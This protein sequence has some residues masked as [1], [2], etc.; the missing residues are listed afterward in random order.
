MES[1]DP[2]SDVQLDLEH[3]HVPH[4]A[5]VDDP[6]TAALARPRF[7]DPQHCRPP[8]SDLRGDHSG[9]QPSLVQVDCPTFKAVRDPRPPTIKDGSPASCWCSFRS[10][11]QRRHLGRITPTVV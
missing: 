1:H 11:H 5:S 3:A 8:D 9:A 4:S 10:T 7:Q 2:L 6:R